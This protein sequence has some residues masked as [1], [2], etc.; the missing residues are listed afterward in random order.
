[1]LGSWL[2]LV[3]PGRCMGRCW[4]E[5]ELNDSWAEGCGIYPSVAS[6]SIRCGR[7]KPPRHAPRTCSKVVRVVVQVL[8]PHFLVFSPRALPS[9]TS[10]FASILSIGE[11]RGI[12]GP[13]GVMTCRSIQKQQVQNVLSSLCPVSLLTRKPTFLV[14]TS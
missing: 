2:E 10:G 12:H 11:N 3:D 5:L 1:M 7:P 8:F 13:F 4:L 9:L 14:R 6:R